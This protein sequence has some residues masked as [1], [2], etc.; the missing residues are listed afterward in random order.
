MT[1]IANEDWTGPDHDALFE[2][3]VVLESRDEAR[4]FLRDLCTRRELEEMTARWAVARL[5]QEGL[6]YREISETTG[7][8]TTTVTRINDWLHHGTGGYR[9][10]LD[11]LG[12]LP[13]ETS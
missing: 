7:V 11:R 2:A 10:I 13:D 12:L 6:S 4:A 9:T 3:V 1:S 5:L 8:S